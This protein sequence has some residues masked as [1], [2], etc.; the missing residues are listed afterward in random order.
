[1]RP[2]VL[3]IEGLAEENVP[4][5]R[6]HGKTKGKQ[7]K[8]SRNGGFRLLARLRQDVDPT[9]LIRKELVEGYILQR[10]CF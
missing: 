4:R 10:Q 7:C 5:T 1:M 8:S 3:A 2:S 9:N 6:N